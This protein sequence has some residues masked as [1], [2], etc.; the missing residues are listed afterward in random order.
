MKLNKQ[1]ATEAFGKNIFHVYLHFGSDSWGVAVSSRADQK[2]LKNKDIFSFFSPLTLWSLA[3][4]KLGWDDD[5]LMAPCP[6]SPSLPLSLLHVPEPCS[7]FVCCG[8]V[9]N[10]IQWEAASPGNPTLMFCLVL[11]CAKATQTP[12]DLDAKTFGM[13][14][15]IKPLHAGTV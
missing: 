5:P 13:G 1:I 4:G 6:S 11:R 9:T 14:S 15:S 7:A 10:E 8:G 3:V 12:T 2:L